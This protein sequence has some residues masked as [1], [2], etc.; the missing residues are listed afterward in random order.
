MKNALV[1]NR[2]TI[3][4]AKDII[5]KERISLIAWLQFLVLALR[6]YCMGSVLQSCLFVYSLICLI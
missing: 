1:Q 4:N 5:A 2:C 6:G 3:E